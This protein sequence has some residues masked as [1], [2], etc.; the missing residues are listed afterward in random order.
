MT[1]MIRAWTLCFDY[2]TVYSDKGGPKFWRIIPPSSLLSE[3][4]CYSA[5][6]ATTSGTITKGTKI[7]S[8]TVVITSELIFTD[9]F[10]Y[11]LLI[12]VSAFISSIC[13]PKCSCIG[14]YI[15]FSRLD[16]ESGQR[17]YWTVDRLFSVALTWRNSMAGIQFLLKPQTKVYFNFTFNL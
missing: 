5:L 11:F 2:D 17:R 6:L 4:I 12:Y 1:R 14:K 9:D 10:I 13:I 8:F 3:V 15:L 7:W 16:W